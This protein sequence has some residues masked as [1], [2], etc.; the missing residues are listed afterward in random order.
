M[1]E[2][3]HLWLCPGGQ[4]GQVHAD[5]CQG[6]HQRNSQLQDLQ[7]DLLGL[8]IYWG[9][10]VL[11]LRVWGQ[12]WQWQSSTWRI[13]N[14]AT[15]S[16][17]HGF[18]LYG[19]WST[20]L[21]QSTIWISGSARPSLRSFLYARAVRKMEYSHR[22]ITNT[23]TVMSLGLGTGCL[24]PLMSNGGHIVTELVMVVMLTSSSP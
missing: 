9:S 22:R 14:F 8:W 1:Q 15:L 2:R 13:F 18:S 12:A 11:G 16:A 5:Q 24:T 17:S 6:H 4:R 7:G 10:G 20:Y 3:L 23:I 21:H 19:L